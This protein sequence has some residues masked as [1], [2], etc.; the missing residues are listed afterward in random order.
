MPRSRSDGVD[1]SRSLVV[2]RQHAAVVAGLRD[3]CTQHEVAGLL[4]VKAVAKPQEV[5]VVIGF[6]T[7]GAP[8]LPPSSPHSCC[9]HHGC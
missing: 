7:D 5:A 8:V 3:E 6:N 1:P 2:S 4:K 9:L